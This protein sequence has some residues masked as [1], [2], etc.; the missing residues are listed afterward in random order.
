[1]QREASLREGPEAPVTLRAEDAAG[2]E[3]CLASGG[4][5]VFPADTVYGLGCD[6]EQR[7]RR[8]APV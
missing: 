7:A 4:V 5:A 6:P 3:C 1:V 8:Q 2:L